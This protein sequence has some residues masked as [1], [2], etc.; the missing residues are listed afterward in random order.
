MGSGIQLVK[1]RESALAA[2]EEYIGRVGGDTALIGITP[3]IDAAAYSANDCICAIQTIAN[4]VRVIGGTG[5]LQSVV[6]Q[7]L[8]AQNA[9]LQILLFSAN[10]ATGTYTKNAE[11]DL[12]DTDAGLCIGIVEIVTSD[13]KTI[14]DNSIA[15]VKGI[16]L[17][18]KCA[19]T[20]LF[21]VIKTT[22]TPTYVANG[23]LKFTFGIL[24]D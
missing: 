19:A 22:G 14:K 8:A 3:T 1:L 23:D 7:D 13:Y 24:R 6:V 17:P 9:V 2:G 12:D 18:I 11:C 21:A 15:T 4:A 5:I 16:G 20:S 10:P